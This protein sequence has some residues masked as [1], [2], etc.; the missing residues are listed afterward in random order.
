ME[1][2]K[3]WFEKFWYDKKSMIYGILAGSVLMQIGHYIVDGKIFNPWVIEAGI[4]FCL[5][6]ILLGYIFRNNR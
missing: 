1:P 3:N 6:T 4:G 2:E 5:F